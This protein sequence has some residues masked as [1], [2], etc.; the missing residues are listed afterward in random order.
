LIV[1]AWSMDRWYRS[2]DNN[3]TDVGQFLT[4]LRGLGDAPRLEAFLTALAGR[5]ALALSA[6]RTVVAALPGDPKHAPSVQPW[7]SHPTLHPECI[8]DLFT[9]LGRIDPTLASVS[10][11]HVLDWPKTY[12]FDT[13]LLPAIIALLASPE[14]AAQPTVQRLR[15]A[16]VVH[17]EA[18]I[19]LPLEAPTDWRRDNTI[20]CTCKDC[21]ALKVFLGHASQKVWIFAAAEARRRHVEATIRAA[22]SDLNTATERR[23]SPHKLICTKNQA[24]YER[25]CAERENDLAKRSTLTG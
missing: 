8:V 18:R 5:H 20:G 15:A 25:R 4:L 6:A 13:I 11:D 23:G 2:R 19:A 10:A 24:S 1:S 17:L 3:R 16:C 9:A 12:D 22:R 14:T 7:S 21:Q